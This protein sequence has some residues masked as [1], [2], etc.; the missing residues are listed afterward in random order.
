MMWSFER[1]AAHTHGVEQ[2]ACDIA[3]VRVVVVKQVNEYVG[4][5]DAGLAAVED[6]TGDVDDGDAL[7]VRAL[8][9][10]RRVIDL[11]LPRP[12]ADRHGHRPAPADGERAGKQREQGQQ[13]DRVKHSRAPAVCAC[14]ASSVTRSAGG[15]KRLEP[16]RARRYAGSLV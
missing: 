7:P 15:V 2:V 12:A 6:E 13:S 4:G 9:E 16:R 14:D 10:H 3:H 5:E 1:L 11:R 8:V